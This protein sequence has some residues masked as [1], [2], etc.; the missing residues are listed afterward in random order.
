VVIRTWVEAPAADWL[1]MSR[2]RKWGSRST[3][4]GEAC[5]SGTCGSWGEDTSSPDSSMSAARTRGSAAWDLALAVVWRVDDVEFGSSG[6]EA[7]VLLSRGCFSKTV[8]NIDASGVAATS[9][10]LSHAS[11]AWRRELGRT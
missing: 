1:Q 3:L 2:L 5:D 10:C 9:N 8:S 11:F 7:S 6:S 4:C